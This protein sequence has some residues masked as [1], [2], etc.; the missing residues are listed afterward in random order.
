MRP[1]LLIVDDQRD[2]LIAL[3]MALTKEGIEVVTAGSPAGALAEVAAEAF[4]AAL[5]DLNYTRDT[6]SGAEGLNLLERLHQNDPLLPV[7]VMTA[8]ASVDLAVQAMRAGARDFIEKPWENARLLSV[9]RNQ[10]DLGRALRSGRRLEAENALLRSASEVQLVAASPAMQEVISLAQR[11]AQS[12]APV[13]ITGENGTGKSLLARLI[14]QWSARGHAL[15]EVN[16]GALPEGVFES[17]M[18]GHLRG[19]F[20]DARAERVGR[21]ELADGGSLFLDEIGNLPAGQQAKLLRVLES[22]EFEPV[23][24]SRTRKANVRLI[25]ATN[26]DLRERVEQGR[27]RQDLLFRINTIEI[28]VPPLRERKADVAPLAG[29][30]LAAVGRRYGRVLRDFEPEAMQALQ[31]YAWPGNVRELR[32]V[33]ERAALLARNEVISVADLRLAP[34]NA[35]PPALEDM[36]LEEAERILIRKALKRHSGSVVD[37]AAALGLSRSALYRRME[38]LG[39]GTDG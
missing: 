18:F 9:I 5:I 24:S 29:A 34:L 15:I 30:A 26:A 8:W 39:I 16:V 38:K 6:T 1:R 7:I 2:V 12:D 28:H 22:G 14:H 3:R 19:A 11:V 37:A 21:V 10:L 4:D 31:R 13:L 35:L 17:E 36:S 32:S 33:I 27:F 25:A 20:T 23:G